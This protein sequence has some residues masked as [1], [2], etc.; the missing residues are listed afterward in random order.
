[1]VDRLEAKALRSGSAEIYKLKMMRDHRR[2]TDAPFIKYLD[3]VCNND[4]M[5]VVDSS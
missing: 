1:V 5:Y 2:K 4:Q 3:K